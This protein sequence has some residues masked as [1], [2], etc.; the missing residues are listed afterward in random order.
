[1]YGAFPYSFILSL[2][3]SWYFMLI[4][5]LIL[6]G[7]LKRTEEFR[8]GLLRARADV[9]ARIKFM[10]QMSHEF[11]SPLNT[12]LGYAELQ[13]RGIQN[14]SP[15][16]N[17]TE[18]K[19]S[20]RHLLSMID[21]IL[22]HSRGEAGQ[23]K[24][25]LAPVNLNTFIAAIC[26]STEMMVAARGNQFQFIQDGIMPPTVIIDQRRL[27]QVLDNLLS[28]ANRYSLDGKIKLHC[29]ASPMA[30]NRSQLSFAVQDNGVGIETNELN[31]IF[32]PFMRGS[33]GKT[34]GIDGTGMGLAIVQQ[35][36]HLMNSQIKVESTLSKGSLFKFSIVCDLADDQNIDVNPTFGKLEKAYKILIV[37]DDQ[38]NINL[39]TLLLTNYGFNIVTANSGNVA[40]HYLDADVAL[41]ITDQFM[42]DG[43]GWLVL[44]DWSTRNMP[45][46]LLSAAPA[47][48]PSNLADHVRFSCILMKPFDAEELLA[49]ITKA[50]KIQWLPTKLHETPILLEV[51]VPPQDKLLHLKA[52][53]EAG[54]VTEIKEWLE[55]FTQKHPEYSDF[56]AKISKAND[57]LDFDM[58]RKLTASTDSYTKI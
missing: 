33:A 18:I 17:A 24:L 14:T 48:R 30:N 50:L 26:Q 22:E 3:F 44:Q 16:A 7:T 40:R 8:D 38:T 25:E 57:M 15:Q 13:E 4:T 51:I 27:R 11:R 49:S 52:L 35:L 2:G 54:A 41:V 55:A 12:I 45:V 1:V 39:L 58:L 34:S 47:L 36:L 19:R 23:L 10:A 43:D 56:C 32:K 53:I 37:D 29:H 46:I 28:N 31:F 20:G 21:E 42:A 5:P 6:A 9:D